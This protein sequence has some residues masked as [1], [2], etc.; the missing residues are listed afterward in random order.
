MSAGPPRRS[1]AASIYGSPCPIQGT[2]RMEMLHDLIRRMT[3][4]ERGP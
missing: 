3:P 1:A 2:E 4:V